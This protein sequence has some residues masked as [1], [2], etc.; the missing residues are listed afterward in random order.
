MPLASGKMVPYFHFTPG[1][2]LWFQGWVPGRGS[3]LLGA[4]VGLFVLALLHRWVV[5]L[6]A[7][8]EVGIASMSRPPTND[9]S[10]AKRKL[11]FSDKIML[12]GVAPFVLD[13]ALSR[14][15]LHIV[16]TSLGFLFMLAVMTSQVSFILSIV[17]G[18]GVG[19]M[20]YGR[21]TYAASRH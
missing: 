9:S 10:M 21:Y 12:H 11:S 17:I 15:L 1:D 16:Q 20:L 6:R 5:A 13:Y 7:A 18:E 3:T 8:W 2:I 19:E 4:C 14:G